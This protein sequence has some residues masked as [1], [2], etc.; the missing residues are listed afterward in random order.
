MIG[1]ITMQQNHS[2]EDYF[3]PIL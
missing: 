1:I 3:M 2:T